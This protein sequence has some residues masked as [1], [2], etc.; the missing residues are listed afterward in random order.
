MHSR[1]SLRFKVALAFS[2][3]TIVLLVAQALGVKALV[4]AQEEK[5][6]DA[7]IADGMRDLIQSY[8]IDPKLVPPLDPRLDGHVSQEG[9]LRILLPASVKEF[10]NGTHEIVLDGREIHVAVAAAEGKRIYRIYDFSVYERHFKQVIDALMVGTGIF[11]LLTIWLAFGL[12]G[13]LV[14]RVAGLA[15]QVKAL[16][17]GASGP[18]VPGKYDEIEVVELVETF[19]D[20]HRRMARMI[21]REEEFTGNVSHELRTPLTTIRTSCELLLQDAALGAKTGMRLRQIER[22]TNNMI[23]LVNALLLLARSESAADIGAL[24]LAGLIADALDDAADALQSG[25]IETRIDIDSDLRV[26]VNRSALAIVLSNLIDNAVRHTAHGCI[27]FSFFDGALRIEDTGSG[28]PPAA[29]PHVFERFY[30]ELPLSA[31]A[32]GFGIGLA[33]VK[34]ICD[35]YQWP[36]RIESELGKGTCVVLGLPPAG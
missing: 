21:E 22:A 1:T 16:R 8:R 7:V 25:E 13:L 18:L 5:F 14:R 2:A 15:G 26:V 17:S 4:E 35:R 19:N 30:R 31:D 27:R 20:Y 9:G 32:P 3:L 23:E 11:A 36:V 29:L 28:I 24:R 12:S 10:G 33:I 6:I 34:K